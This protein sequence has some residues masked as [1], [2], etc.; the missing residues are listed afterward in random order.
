MDKRCMNAMKRMKGSL[1]SEAKKLMN[2]EIKKIE[3]MWTVVDDYDFSAKLAKWK[4]G[5]SL[6]NADVLTEQLY[7]GLDGLASG[8]GL[9]TGDTS[10]LEDMAKEQLITALIALV[11]IPPLP[12]GDLVD[13]LKLKFNFDEACSIDKPEIKV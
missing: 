2:A 3:D 9:L 8:K 5:L 7:D 12:L 1:I 6:D 4:D 11:P 10:G 13:D